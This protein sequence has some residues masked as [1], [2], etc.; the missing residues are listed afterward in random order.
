MFAVARI[1]TIGRLGG[2]RVAMVWDGSVWRAS[3]FDPPAPRTTGVPP[4]EWLFGPSVRG[5]P[6]VGVEV[7]GPARA[8]PILGRQS[9][10]YGRGHV[11]QFMATDDA[12]SSC[13][14]PIILYKKD[15]VSSKHSIRECIAQALP[16]CDYL[17]MIDSWVKQHCNHNVGVEE[18]MRN[19][20]LSRLEAEAI[21]WWTADVGLIGEPTEKSPY[22]VFNTDLRCRNHERIKLWK[23][24][25]WYLIKALEKLPR[26]T[27]IAFRGESKKVTQLS[28]QYVA[29][30]Q[31][32]SLNDHFTLFY[33]K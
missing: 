21:V 16:D 18:A 10:F 25:A 5:W 28:K 27:G 33:L 1:I 13:G 29:D 23:D 17:D 31:V 24:F 20:G 14:R 26:F 19:Y 9:A 3:R 22:Y 6:V 30:K 4:H 2:H 7:L 32:R 11:A 8:H 12:V 15:F